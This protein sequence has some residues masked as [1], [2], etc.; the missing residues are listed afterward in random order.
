MEPLV[1]S[2]AMEA[3][4]LNIGVEEENCESKTMRKSQRK[5]SEFTQLVGG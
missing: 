4:C 2:E 5:T 1:H 3:G